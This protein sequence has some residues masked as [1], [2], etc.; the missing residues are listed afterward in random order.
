MEAVK[1]FSQTAQR[2]NKEVRGESHAT[3]HAIPR[4]RPALSAASPLASA[5]HAPM[6]QRFASVMAESS[7][8]PAINA[9]SSVPAPAP[10][11]SHKTLQSDVNLLRQELVSL[12][13]Q[14]DSVTSSVRTRLATLTAENLWLT[15]ELL[16]LRGRIM[17]LEEDQENRDPS[18][19]D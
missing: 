4:R 17:A 9:S 10:S 8:P 15:S 5:P 6:L 19:S 16:A 3:P 11:G 1:G 18:E 7:S 2:A 13:R 14:V 12:R